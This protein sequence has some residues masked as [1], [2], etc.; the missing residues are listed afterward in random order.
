M[1]QSRLARNSARKSKLL[2]IAHWLQRQM[3]W[4]SG[5][6]DAIFNTPD[7]C[8]ND[9]EADDGS[10]PSSDSSYTAATSEGEEDH[11]DS[12]MDSD[13]EM[14]II[15]TTSRSEEDNNTGNV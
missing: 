7:D 3:M 8:N 6:G 4:Y 5:N 12:C 1:N 11:D 2:G 15:T 10:S 9:I 14:S 13:D